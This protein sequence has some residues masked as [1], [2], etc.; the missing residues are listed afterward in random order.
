MPKHLEMVIGTSG[1]FRTL[2]LTFEQW[3]L[4]SKYTLLFLKLESNW[5]TVYTK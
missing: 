2:I 5:I 3:Y 4:N 1:E